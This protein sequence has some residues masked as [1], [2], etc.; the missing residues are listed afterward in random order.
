M[1]ASGADWE[2]LLDMVYTKSPPG[3]G[4]EA[5]AVEF[6]LVAADGGGGGDVAA[7]SS[8]TSPTSLKAELHRIHRQLHLPLI[9]RLHQGEVDTQLL[10]FLDLEPPSIAKLIE[11]LPP[12][13]RPALSIDG[14]G[15]THILVGTRAQ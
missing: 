9:Q 11:S 1:A 3:P 15:G 14:P 6:L 12:R 2:G 13:L 8:A 10:N 4:G 7:G 5:P